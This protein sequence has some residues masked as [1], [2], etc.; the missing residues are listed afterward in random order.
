MNEEG[1]GSYAWEWS[2]RVIHV[3]RE[4]Y[5]EIL[6]GEGAQLYCQNWQRGIEALF[7]LSILAFNVRMEISTNPT[8]FQLPNWETIL[9]STFTVRKW[10]PTPRSFRSTIEIG[11]L[12]VK[13]HIVEMSINPA[14]LHLLNLNLTKE[15]AFTICQWESSPQRFSSAVEL[16]LIKKLGYRPKMSSNPVEL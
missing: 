8:D 10:P 9:K 14:E 3:L 16:G 6:R 13:I 4:K 12:D 1:F 15:R 7:W 5:S 2:V 11:I